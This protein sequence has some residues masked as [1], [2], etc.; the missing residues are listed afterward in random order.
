MAKQNLQTILCPPRLRLYLLLLQSM[1]VLVYSYHLVSPISR[2][3]AGLGAVLAA[4]TLFLL[5][6]PRRHIE[7]AWFISVVTLGNLIVL[8]ATFGVSAH[9]WILST[10]VLLI[11]M[12]SYAPSILHFSV[13][14]SLII[15]GYGFVLHQA[16]VLGPD[17]ILVVPLLFCLTLVFVSKITTAQAEI[18]RIVKMD[19]DV[20]PQQRTGL[21]ALTGLPNRAQF[22]ERLERIVQYTDHN[23]HFRFAV[24]FIDLDGFKPINDKLGHKAGDAVLRHVARIFQ[25]CVRQGDVVGRYGGDEF[26]CLLNQINHHSEATQI[27]ERML[28][29][30]QAPIDVGERVTVG[31]SIGI[32]FNTNIGE[33]TEELLRDADQAMYRAKAQGKNRYVISDHKVDV[34]PAEFISRW[35][36]MMQLKWY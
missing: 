20:Q 19:D 32:A 27:V 5:T 7:T 26:I 4:I 30:L 33:T 31:A 12:A 11:S 28:A 1:F 24:L 23:R 15:G 2:V 8:F 29:R 35:K 10:V 3:Q 9:L 22:L 14:S 18:Q 34:P 21:D 25:S 16:G 6:L 36:R 17:E 13:L